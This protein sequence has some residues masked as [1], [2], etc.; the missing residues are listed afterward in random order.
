MNTLWIATL[1]LSGALSLTYYV[2]RL[3]WHRRY[4]GHAP[5]SVRIDGRVVACDGTDLLVQ[6]S[7]RGAGEPRSRAE[8]S[9]RDKTDEG[10]L[11]RRVRL[12]GHTAPPVE[13]EVMVEGRLLISVSEERLYRQSAHTCIAATR[14]VVGR[15]PELRWLQVP[16]VLACLI[17]LL[18]LGQ[19]L[20]G[21]TPTGRLFE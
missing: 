12:Q 3:L 15:W 14:L 20:F 16:V 8:W 2:Y 18:S 1:V 10:G 5:G 7:A 9:A 6:T 11:L 19:L 17:W 4:G 13:S 21:A